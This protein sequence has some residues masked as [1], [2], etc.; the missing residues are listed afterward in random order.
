M[1]DY[2]PTTEEVREYVV[3]G[4]EYRPWISTDDVQELALEAQRGEDFDRWL[5]HHD[6]Q[7]AAQALREARD[8]LARSSVV[9]I[10]PFGERLLTEL[11]DRIE[12]Q[13][14]AQ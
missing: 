12:E 13:G 8:M 10:T 3:N 2:T 4:G 5:A 1:T 11:S 6:A 7:V 9:T 14:Q